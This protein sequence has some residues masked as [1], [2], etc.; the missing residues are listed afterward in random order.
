MNKS[1]FKKQ[2]PDVSVQEITLEKVLSRKDKEEIVSKLVAGLNTGL[3]TYE[4][5]GRSLKIFTSYRLKHAID[6]MTK[7]AKVLDENSGRFGMVT[8]E[9]PFI[10][11]C[12]M[13]IRVDF[14]D[15]SDVYACSYFA[16]Q[17]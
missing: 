3:I 6:G 16:K 8:S 7:G 5:G 9:Q 12:E 13:C 11:G 2:F 14:G 17:F 4:D 1:T 10:L 15:S